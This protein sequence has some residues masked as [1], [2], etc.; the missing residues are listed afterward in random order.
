MTAGSHQNARWNPRR[1]TT[2]PLAPVPRSHTNT[3]SRKKKSLPSVSTQLARARKRVR[4]ARLTPTT[5]LSS[6]NAMPEKSSSKHTTQRLASVDG[7]RKTAGRKDQSASALNG[8][9]LT[10]R[11]HSVG[12]ARHTVTTQE[13]AASQRLAARAKDNSKQNL[14]RG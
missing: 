6:H 3:G 11:E 4:R 14:N 1:R 13:A 8:P 2:F 7:G 10:L 5:D 9:L 12:A